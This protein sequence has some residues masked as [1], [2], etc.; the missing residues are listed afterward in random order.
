MQ[1]VNYWSWPGHPLHKHCQEQA[2]RGSPLLDAHSREY[3]ETKNNSNN[4]FSCIESCLSWRE[5]LTQ[6]LAKAAQEGGQK[7]G[8]EWGLKL[9]SRLCG[10][11]A[12]T[13]MIPSR[14]TWKI[15]LSSC[16]SAEGRL[17]QRLRRLGKWKKQEED[18]GKCKLLNCS[19]DTLVLVEGVHKKTYLATP[20]KK[21]E[22]QNV[23][24]KNIWQSNGIKEGRGAE[25]VGN[26]GISVCFLSCVECHYQTTQHLPPLPAMP[27]FHS[28]NLMRLSS[29][30]KSEPP[31]PHR[32]R[33]QSGDPAMSRR[34]SSIS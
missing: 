20:A 30:M 15:Y 9:F 28:T 12:L 34:R 16:H 19:L 27:L 7:E 5:S 8:E 1:L 31:P 22:K 6:P 23:K 32:T 13:E 14:A 10:L 4:S 21:K 17:R 26:C 3:D 2:R 29:W 11:L 25:G 18:E 33:L 24:K